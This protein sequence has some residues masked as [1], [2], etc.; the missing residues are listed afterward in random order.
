MGAY[1]VATEQ[2]GPGIIGKRYDLFYGMGF[3]ISYKKATV[4]F[5]MTPKHRL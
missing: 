3:T 2:N 4:S 1:S 5:I